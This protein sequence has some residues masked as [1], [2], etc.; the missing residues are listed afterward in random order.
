[1]NDSVVQP[2]F[3]GVFMK[4][5]PLVSLLAVLPLVLVTTVA[6]ADEEIPAPVSHAASQQTSHTAAQAEG[7]P[8]TER[9]PKSEWYGW[10]ILTADATSMMVALGG[11]VSLE[12]GKPAI[13]GSIGYLVA[14]PIIHGA[15]GN[16]GAALG[17]LGL[18]AGLPAVGT[19]AGIFIGAGSGHGES[20][21]Y[22]A[23]VGGVSG[24]VLGVGLATFLDT[25]ILAHEV[26]KPT[27]DEASKVQIRPNIAVSQKGAQV[28]LSGAF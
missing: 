7:T 17:S 1:M 8:S 18:R 23:A 10:Q 5:R 11:T 19:L 24:F 25:A 9:T 4:S 2:L 20:G 28:S 26:K 13:L 21:M 15:H 22:S 14:S 12:N 27:V 6:H 3:L 16:G